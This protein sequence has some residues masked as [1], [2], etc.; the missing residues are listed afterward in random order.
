MKFQYYFETAG[1]A[2]SILKEQVII[3]NNSKLFQLEPEILL[4]NNK[5]IYL[6]N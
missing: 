1:N 2:L 3:V 4:L 5:E 6:I